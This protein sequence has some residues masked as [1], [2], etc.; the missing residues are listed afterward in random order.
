MEKSEKE[1]LVGF[2]G[3]KPLKEILEDLRDEKDRI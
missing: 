1:S 2:L 3:K